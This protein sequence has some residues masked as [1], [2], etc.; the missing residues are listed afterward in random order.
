MKFLETRFVRWNSMNR[1]ILIG[2]ML[3]ALTLQACSSR[4]REFTP[5]LAAPAS[6][7]TELDTA[8]AT[9]RQLL[10]EGMLDSNGR[11]ASGAVGVAAG[12]TTVALGTAAASR[13]LSLRPPV[14]PPPN[15]L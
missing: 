14:A 10:V 15:R 7:Q 9:C 5:E 4:P 12:A 13:N 6:N 8:Y 2:V 11:L 1:S 3:P